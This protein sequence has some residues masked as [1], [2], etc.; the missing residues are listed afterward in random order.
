MKKFASTVDP[1]SSCNA[2]GSGCTSLDDLAEGMEIYKDSVLSSFPSWTTTESS[3]MKKFKDYYGN[4]YDPDN[5]VTSA[6][7]G[8]ET[9][10]DNGADFGDY[11]GSPKSG[12]SLY[13]GR[14]ECAKKGLGYTTVKLEVFQKLEE[15]LFWLGIG[16]EDDCMLAVNAWDKAVAYWV[17]S[18]EGEDGNNDPAG[19]YGVFPYALGDKR[20]TNFGTCGEDGDSSDKDKPAQANTKMINLFTKGGKYVKDGDLSDAKDTVEKI[21]SA[22]VVPYIQGTLRYAYKVGELG[23][24][25]DKERAEGIAFAYGALPQIN[26]C[27]SDAA[28][29]IYDNMKV[30]SQSIDFAEVKSALESVYDCLGITCSDVGGLKDG[31]AYY[32]GAEPC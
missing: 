30:G 2:D 10:F 20:C 5:W 25:Y 21:E 4:D 26:A 1:Q 32:T 27:D 19:S 23:S 18:L 22:S 16:C 6:L 11:P 9:D 29:T 28:D 24:N 17:G 12:L 13:T 15:A 7:E 31:D 3:L 14:E 8:E